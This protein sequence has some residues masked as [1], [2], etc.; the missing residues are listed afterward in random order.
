MG[1]LPPKQTWFSKITDGLGRFQLK[2]SL[3]GLGNNKTPFL[4]IPIFDL[5]Q[6]H[7]PKQGARI[8]LRSFAF[9]PTHSSDNPSL[10]CLALQNN[11]GYHYT[12]HFLK[13]MRGNLKQQKNKPI[14]VIDEPALL[15]PYY[16]T[17]FGHFTGDCLGAIIALSN[18]A[19]TENRKLFFIA[20]NQFDET[21]LRY[22][23]SDRLQKINS[24]Q[25]FSS[26]LIFSDACLLPRISP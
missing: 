16:T 18:L 11:I 23:K 14:I 8:E 10:A 25:A 20:P 4:P 13:D 3:T 15:L 7:I 24:A 6:V 22:G 17:H 9:G 1:Y 19:P 2:E 5:N 26:N 12:H 21:I